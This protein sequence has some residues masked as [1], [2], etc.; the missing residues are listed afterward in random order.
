MTLVWELQ[1]FLPS[2]RAVTCTPTIFHVLAERLRRGNR[3]VANGRERRAA[4]RKLF[5]LDSD[6]RDLANACAPLNPSE[7]TKKCLPI[8]IGAGFRRRNI[9]PEQGTMA[10]PCHF[11]ESTGLPARKS[12]CGGRFA[13]AFN[14]PHHMSLRGSRETSEQ[15][16]DVA[17]LLLVK[18]RSEAS[19][20][21]E[22]F[23]GGSPS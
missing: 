19:R 1:E 12:G 8:H 20:K 13:D 2:R 21:N 3:A 23:R 18:P 6:R 5:V 7:T 16:P 17:R 9:T 4:C 15:E 14:T 10:G 22:T 11:R